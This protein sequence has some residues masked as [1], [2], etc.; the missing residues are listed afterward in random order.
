MRGRSVIL[1]RFPSIAER[2]NDAIQLRVVRNDRAAFAHR[3]MMRRIERKCAD[4]SD[5]A[6]VFI[7]PLRAQSVAGIFDQPQIVLLA[8]L[9][10]FIHVVHIA[11]R[12][13]QKDALCSRRNRFFDFVDVDVVGAG[14]GINEHGDKPV[15]K[16]RIETCTSPKNRI[17][18]IC[19]WDANP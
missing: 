7:I 16:N 6:G 13:R 12:M 18:M 14:F 3:Q 9:D 17:Y 15:L 19:I 5:R 1:A 8:D 10:D 2:Q 4:M 11:Q